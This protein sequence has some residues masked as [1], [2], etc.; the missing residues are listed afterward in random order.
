MNYDDELDFLQCLRSISLLEP[1]NKDLLQLNLDNIDDILINLINKD[2]WILNKINSISEKSS[3]GITQSIINY[4]LLKDPQSQTNIGK[5]N[6]YIINNIF[7]NDTISEMIYILIMHVINK[8]SIII[9]SSEMNNLRYLHKLFDKYRSNIKLNEVKPFMIDNGILPYKS[10]IK[11]LQIKN[12]SLHEGPVIKINVNNTDD[13]YNKMI[14]TI[15]DTMNNLENECKDKYGIIGLWMIAFEINHC[16]III[17]D[18]YNNKWIR[19]EPGGHRFYKSPNVSN[20][21][22]NKFDK[23][24]N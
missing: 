22:S 5:I 12:I 16:N 10:I 4:H 19:I 8:N 23:I 14:K 6:R 20:K 24:L 2:D 21:F 9:E 1:R 7:L 15:I 3:R 18:N 13:E 17:Y 11:I